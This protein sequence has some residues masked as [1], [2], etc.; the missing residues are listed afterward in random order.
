MKRVLIF[1]SVV[2]VAIVLTSVTPALSYA[3]TAS[4]T[5]ANA[6][7]IESQID[8]NTQQISSIQKDI[9]A[10]TQQL[11]TLSTKKQ[12]L[13]STIS[14]I[15]LNKEKTTDE[16]NQTEDQIQTANLTLNQLGSQITLKQAA[17][18]LDQQALAASLRQIQGDDQVPFVAALFSA[19]S[20]ANVWEDIGIETQ[21]SESLQ[22]NAANLSDDKVQL[23]SQQQQ[24]ANTKTSLVSDTTNLQTQSGE[25]AA[26]EEAKQELLA[27]TNSQQ[28]TYQTLLTEKKAEEAQF[29]SELTSLQNS[30]KGISPSAVP[31]AGQ[32]ILNWPFA[33]SI[34]QNCVGKQ[35]ALG[36]PYCITQY[37]G[38]TPFAT[39]NPAIYSGMGHD[40]VDI[41]VPIGTPVE[42]ALDGVVAGT[43]DTDLIHNA[44]GNQCYSFG[45]WIMIQHP[46]GLN[47]MYAHLSVIGVTK[48]EQVTTGQVIGYSGMTGYA[49]GPH[50]HFGVYAT[51]GVQ[52]TTLGAFHGTDT[53]CSD[54]TMPVAPEDAYL[55]PL[56]Y[57]L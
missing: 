42:A 16:I 38:N 43:G 6:S 3:Q 12:T 17:I 35:G 31:V 28:S 21:L 53:P 47:T 27:Q 48:G 56:S 5:P 26:T 7:A 4:G 24:V 41:G 2:F 1:A 25:L 34:M 11:N 15:D 36:N 30:L 44:A 9:D 57:L 20:F 29:E 49:T 10:Y 52:Y 22:S 18:N 8:Q 23:T 13:Q 51:A 46:N 40:G 33:D 55:N 39:A 19:S 45:K 14:S 54:A 50:L 37:F 32:G